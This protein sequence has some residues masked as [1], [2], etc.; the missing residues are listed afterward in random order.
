MIRDLSCSSLF[1]T[2]NAIDM[3]WNDLYTRMLEYDVYFNAIEQKK[4]RLMFRLLQKNLHVAIEYLNRR[5]R[6]FFKKIL[7][8]KC[9]IKDFWYR[10]E[11]QTR[12]NNHVHDFVWLKNAFSLEQLKTYFVFWSLLIIVINSEN[13]LSFATRHSSSVFFFERN[14]IKFELAKLLNRVQKHIVCTFVYCLRQNK[15]TKKVVCRFHFFRSERDVV[16]VIYNVNFKR[17]IYFSFQNDSF[18]N[19]YNFII[20][21]K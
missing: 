19:N 12:E 20:S 2:F 17:L 4:H 21:I 5:F 7:K 16:V 1:L 3:Q 10:Y 9:E 18:F 13:A 8:K 14:N 6:L 15:K 11:W